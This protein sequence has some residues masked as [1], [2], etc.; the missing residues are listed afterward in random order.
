VQSFANIFVGSKASWFSITN[1]YPQYEELPPRE[2]IA[3]I[4]FG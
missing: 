2:K 4:L 1:N 3:E